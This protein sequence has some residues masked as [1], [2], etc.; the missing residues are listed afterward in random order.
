MNLSFNVPK[1]WKQDNNLKEEEDFNILFGL[2]WRNGVFIY[3][4]QACLYL[5]EEGGLW[6]D[7]RDQS[8][9]IKKRQKE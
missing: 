1:H 2:S 5:C 6:G 7:N 4:V 9:E 8:V 3:G